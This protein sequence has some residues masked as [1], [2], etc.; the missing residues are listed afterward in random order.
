MIKEMYIY[1]TG[2]T[3][4]FGPKSSRF[5]W[6]KVGATRR[7]PPSVISTAPGRP[8]PATNR[9]R[10]IQ[11]TRKLIDGE[12]RVHARW[13]LTRQLSRSPSRGRTPNARGKPNLIYYHIIYTHRRLNHLPDKKGP[14]RY[15]QGRHTPS[16]S[17]SASTSRRSSL[18]PHS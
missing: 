16:A 14:H 5:V 2:M 10:D 9:E 4:N 12:L 17:A 15:R 11:K 13:W 3:L 7:I 18:P 1:S 6:L 8:T